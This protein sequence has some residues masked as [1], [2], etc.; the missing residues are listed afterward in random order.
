MFLIFTTPP[1]LPPKVYGLYT[2]ENV[3]I[4]GQPLKLNSYIWLKIKGS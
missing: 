1:P 3:D 4:C 2:R